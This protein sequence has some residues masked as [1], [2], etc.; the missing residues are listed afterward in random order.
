MAYTHHGFQQPQEVIDLAVEAA[1]GCVVCRKFVRL[2]NRPQVRAGGA[3]IF[4]ETVQIDLFTLNGTNSMLMVDEAIRFKTC[5]IPEGQKAPQLMSCMFQ[6]WIQI[7]RPPSRLALDQEPS[8]MGHDAASEFERLGIKRVPKGTT[9]GYGADQ[10]TGTGLVERHVQ[11]KLTMQKLQTELQR[12]GLNPEPL[13]L[14]QESAMAHNQT[15]NYGRVTPCMSVFGILPRGFCNPKSPGVMSRDGAT[16]RDITVFERAMRIRQTTLAQTRQ[17]IIED[18]VARANKHRP[19][20]LETDQ[21]TAGTS[22]VEYYREIAG[23]PGWRGPAL[24]LRLDQGEGVAVIQY[25]GKPYLVPLRHIRPYRGV[26]YFEMQDDT[27]EQ[28]LTRLMR[29]TEGLSDYKVYIIG[30]IRKGKDGRWTK[31]PK[32][33]PMI[34]NIMQWADKISKAMTKATLHGVMMGRSLRTFKPPNNTH[35]KLFT[36][37]QGGK[38]YSAQEHKNSNHLRMKKISNYVRENL[39]VMYFFYYQDMEPEETTSLPRPTTSDSDAPKENDKMDTDRQSVKRDGPETRTVVLAP[40][41]KK[42]KIAMMKKDVEFLQ[43]YYLNSN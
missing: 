2:P 26:F 39:C 9:R 14:G 1:K 36:W 13:E 24:L 31:T 20:Q 33:T 38:A 28:E 30:W 11:L 37:I 34:T 42:Q 40:E 3:T 23:D 35:G 19:H 22:E 8:L 6:C 43:T 18:R 16:Q 17:A 12:Q 41:K 27:V 5:A 25:Q 21:L 32:E 7:F 15:I 4:N 29:Y 10:H